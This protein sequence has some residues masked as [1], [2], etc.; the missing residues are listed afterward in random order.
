MFDFIAHEGRAHDEDPPGPG[1]GRYRWGSGENPHQH[2]NDISSN[3]ASLREQGLKDSEIA[4]LLFGEKATLNTLRAEIAIET[5]RKWMAQRERALKLY[6]ENDNNASE[7]ARIMFGDAKKESTVRNLLKDTLAYRKTKYDSTAEKLKELVDKNNGYLDVGKDTEHYLGVTENTKKVALYMLQKEYGYKIAYVNVPQLGTRHTT[8]VMTLVS[9]DIEYKDVFNLTQNKIGTISDFSP[10]DGKT[11]FTPKYPKSIDSSRVYIRYKEDGGSDKDGVI[12][13]RK[14]VED[15]SLG[16]SR[17]AQVRI[18]VDNKAYMKGMA[19][20]GDDSEMPEGYDVVYNTNKKRGAKI[21]PD[22]ED[23]P[24]TVMKHLKIDK[25]TGEVDKENPFG[26]LIKAGGQREYEE[27]GEKKLSVINKLQEEGDWDSWGR[28]LSS[29]ALAKQPQK[30][31]DQQLDLTIKEKRAQLDEILSLTNPIVKQKMLENFAG[32]CDSN[33][34]DLAAVGFKNQAFQVLLPVS[35]LKMDEIYAPNFKDGDRVALIRY[36][37]GGIFEILDL[38]VNN[39]NKK[40]KSIMGNA[41][42]AVGINPKN[43]EVLSGADFDGDTALVIPQTSNNIK[44]QSMKPLDALKGF[45]NKEGYRLPESAPPVKNSTKQ[46]EMGKVTN[47]IMDMTVGGADVNTDIAKAVKHSMVVIDS[48]KHHLDMKQS[49]EDFDIRKLKI[50]YQGVNDKGEPKGASTILT[51]A[52]SEAHIPE[53]KEV[54]DV[55]KMTPEELE[56]WNKGMRV[57]RNTGKTKKKEIKNPKKMTPEEL[58]RYKAGKK[59]WRDSDELVTI[60]VNQM[61]T[62]DD[63][64]QLVRDPFNEKEIAYAKFANELKALANEARRESRSIK[65]VKVNKQAAKTYEKEVK[66]LK[67]AVHKAEMNSPRERKAQAIGNALVSAKFADNPDMDY[68]HRQR[69]RDIAIRQA[70]NM[71]GAH[72]EKIEI[73]PR[74]WDAIQNNAISTQLLRNIVGNTD[75]K[76]LYDLAM[77]KNKT[78]LSESKK[79][80]ALSMLR[81]EQYSISEIADKFGVSTSTIRNLG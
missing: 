17:Y 14:G 75:Q 12:E 29:Q 76:K 22:Y 31:I 79:A 58:E 64:M 41:K 15:I 18:A 2:I 81:S 65:P 45:D 38:K 66:E 5:K 8:T 46:T 3:V 7:V 21:I 57:W 73:T 59:V 51:R 62:V 43:A 32:K 49:Y 35:D 6:D 55:Y 78:G 9:P 25:A 71:V 50:K 24:G 33:A 1:S 80:L 72:K 40:A 47:L 37:H 54:T 53:R 63:A 67:D 13:L 28:T 42:D 10:D 16:N 20:Y 69:Q 68:E 34:A 27:N 36:P 26:A 30:L 77:P 48:E 11:W 19:I 74:Q 60:K 52:K 23:E 70:R 56:R 61:D 44:I 39:S 4:K